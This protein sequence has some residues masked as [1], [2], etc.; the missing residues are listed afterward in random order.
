MLFD[1]RVDDLLT[2]GEKAVQ[3]GRGD[4]GA[5][6]DGP[7][8]DGVNA[9]FLEEDGRG[10]EDPLDGLAAAGLNRLPASAAGPGRAGP[11]AGRFRGLG[12][13]DCGCHG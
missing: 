13:L 8:G 1:Q 11:G 6:G 3:R 12:G 10:A 7:G 4:V 5:L 2:V 9:A